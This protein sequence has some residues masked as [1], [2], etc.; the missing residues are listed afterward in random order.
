MDGELS[1]AVKRAH[2]PEE[3]EAVKSQRIDDNTESSQH[4]SVFAADL[5]ET[6]VSSRQSTQISPNILSLAQSVSPKNKK[7]DCDFL[8]NLLIGLECRVFK[9]EQEL[10]KKDKAISDLE[11]K[12]DQKDE[13][14]SSLK[15]DLE[16]LQTKIE[17]IIPTPKSD[18]D[19]MAT[20]KRDYHNT[21]EGLA[22]AEANI[23]EINQKIANLNTGLAVSG[24]EG[25][26]GPNEGHESLGNDIQRVDSE[27]K[28]I[29]DRAKKQCRRD[30][31]V[32]DKRDQYSRRENLRVTG[33][34]FHQG[35]DTNRIM[36]AI[37]CDLGVTITEADISVSHRS[38]KRIG[39]N[40][41]PILCKF[42]RRDVKNQLLANKMRARN[43]KRDPYDGRLVKIYVDEDLTSMRARVCKKLRQDRVPHYTR[44]GKVYI[45]SADSDSQFKVHDTP[46]DWESLEWLDSVKIDVGVY[47]QD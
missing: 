13:V 5:F 39:D 6:P 29:R 44:D 37:A 3:V 21:C 17:D 35:E 18:V 1:T 28:S 33:V 36:I 16:S 26:L 27:I 30:H 20:L 47:P 46:E 43:I 9:T 4:P 24:M 12:L 38:G 45:A 34:P 15:N 32:G 7:I 11:N 31:L 19:F 2:S 22:T 41:R 42:V 40:P 10:E 25:G 8:Y 23:T 14:I